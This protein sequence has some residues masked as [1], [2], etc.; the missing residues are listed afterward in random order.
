MAA[1]VGDRVQVHYTGSVEDTV[2]DSSV[3]RDPIEFR[4]GA[5]EVIPG[6][7]EAV[8][9]MVVGEKKTFYIPPE[10]AYGDRVDELIQDV[11]MDFFEGHPIEVGQLIHLQSHD[12]R[13]LQALV[14]DVTEEFATL[15][16]NHPLAG[17]TLTFEIEL[18]NIE[19]ERSPIIIP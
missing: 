15:D 7:E 17:K 8:V 18:M 5:G 19:S 16:M 3:G 1:K 12:G 6:F 2:F 14:A 10:Q 11:P 9:G 13:V 4:V